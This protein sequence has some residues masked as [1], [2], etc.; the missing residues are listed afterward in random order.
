MGHI[1]NH[2]RRY[3][4]LQQRLDRTLTGAP[5][6]PTFI[7]ILKIL[8]SPE[9][10]ELARRIPGQPT[11]LNVLSHKLN[12]PADKLD[13]RLNQMAQRGLVID[14]EHKGQRYFTLSPVVIGFFE[15]TFMRTRD[16]LPMAELA[17]LFDEYFNQDDRF[18]HS[19]F[20]GQTQLGRR[21]VRE[22]AIP[23]D[24]HTEILDWERAS[25]IIQT[26]SPIAVS[27]C[28]CRHEL[29]HLGKACD[30][31]QL[32]CLS[33]NYAADSVIRH[34]IGKAITTKEAINILE[35]CKEAGLAQTADNVQRKV[36]YICNCCGCCCGMV[37]AIKTYNIRN[38]IVSSNWIME[39]DL[40]KCKGCGKCVKACPT[41]A[42][43]IMEKKEGGK[44]RRWAVRDETLCLGCGVC[45]SACKSGAISLK[46]RPQRVLTPETIFDQ[47]A[48]MAIERGKLADLLFPEREK[49]SHR[50]LGRVI[51]ILEKSPP[52]KAA[53][54]ISPLRSVFLSTLVKGAKKQMGEI[55]EVIG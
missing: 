33:L 13:D 51:D 37:Q 1:I 53:M 41:E 34:G 8:F 10:V 38:A 5:E 31:P 30:R 16:D 22:E 49:L 54:A 55:S 7:K 14:L 11:T 18:S 23:D 39:I 44:R 35:A 21:L 24:A 52:F 29:S 17:R 3:Q 6:S 9:E 28:P 12:I 46:P 19:V 42:I 43:E 2:D 25:Q 27:L 4:L 20:Q 48:L 50:A 26:A 15:F 47:V 45:Y 36:T 40:T 32:T